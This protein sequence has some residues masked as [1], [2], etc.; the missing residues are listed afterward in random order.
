MLCDLFAV[1]NDSELIENISSDFAQLAKSRLETDLQQISKRLEKFS[2]NRGVRISASTG[3][4][5]RYRVV[6]LFGCS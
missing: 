2:H 1:S 6:I 4:G 5:V 3:N